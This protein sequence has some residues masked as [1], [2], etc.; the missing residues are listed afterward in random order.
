MKK[1]KKNLKKLRLL[2][3]K[4]NLTLKKL[5]LRKPQELNQTLMEIRVV[6]IEQ[7]YQVRKLTRQVLVSLVSTKRLKL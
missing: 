3:R 1:R 6:L 7:V 4:K 5:K 2:K